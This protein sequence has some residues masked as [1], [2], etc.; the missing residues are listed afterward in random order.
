MSVSGTLDVATA[1]GMKWS[2]RDPPNLLIFI[3]V[4]RKK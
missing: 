1:C 2:R 3:Q 4:I